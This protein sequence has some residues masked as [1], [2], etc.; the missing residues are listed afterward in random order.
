M[1]CFIFWSDVAA[2]LMS[3]NVSGELYNFYTERSQKA[4]DAA[5]ASENEA[6][7]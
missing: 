3:N 4:F 5:N 1:P 2:P 7:I 6:Y